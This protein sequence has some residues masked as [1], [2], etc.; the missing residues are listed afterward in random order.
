MLSTIAHQTRRSQVLPGYP[1][2]S[3]GAYECNTYVYSWPN[4][5]LAI[6][7]F[8]HQ[9]MCEYILYALS[10]VQQV[11]KKFVFLL[12]LLLLQCAVCWCTI[13]G[14]WICKYGVYVC[15]LLCTW[16]ES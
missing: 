4:S 16:K 6:F 8:L 2:I 14:L 7:N 13:R 3:A 15:V 10:V 9:S 12:L 11:A 5:K 1:H